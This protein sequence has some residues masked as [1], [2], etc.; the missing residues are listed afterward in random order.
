MNQHT[1][2]ALHKLAGEIE[3][4]R[5][6]NAKHYPKSVSTD[7]SRHERDR[8]RRD[9][10]RDQTEQADR[11]KA[12]VEKYRLQELQ[13]DEREKA[14]VEKVK[15]QELEQSERERL[16]VEKVKRQEAEQAE[17]EKLLVE[18]V[19][20]DEAKQKEREKQLIAEAKRQEAEQ[21]ARDREKATEAVQKFKLAEIDRAKKEKEQEEAIAAKIKARDDKAKADD[22]ARVKEYSD[23]AEL[24]AI[25]QKAGKAAEQAKLEAAMRETLARNGVPDRIITRIIKQS[26]VTTATPAGAPAALS[27]GSPGSSTSPVVQK[28]FLAASTL[29]AFNVPV[30]PGSV[31]QFLLLAFPSLCPPLYVLI[32]SGMT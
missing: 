1:E 31:S 11:E 8:W 10:L 19:K 16:L 3:R 6:E 30:E 7:H 24:R 17:R 21:A 14:L 18:K 13:R 20:L 23:K 4:I 22:A 29:R 5:H 28:K 27:A 32:C 15:R 9:Y 25:A 12:L 2:F 26:T